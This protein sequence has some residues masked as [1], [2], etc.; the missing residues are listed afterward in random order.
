MVLFST[1]DRESV[2]SS[3]SGIVKLTILSFLNVVDI[4]HLVSP[5]PVI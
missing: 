3:L 1:L 2:G 4:S 5:I